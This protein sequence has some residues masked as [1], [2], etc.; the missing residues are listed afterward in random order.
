MTT[1]TEEKVN[2]KTFEKDLF[3]LMCQIACGLIQEYLLWRDLT[4]MAIRDKQRFR[5]IDS[6]RE[7]TIKTVFGEVRYVRR[8]Y[9]DNEIKRYIFLLDVALGIDDG[10]GLISENLAE[11]I[12][13]EAADKSY[14][15]AA[16]T[17][18]THTGQRISAQG[19]WNVL[20][21]YGNAIERQETRLAE[22]E[23]SG[24]VGHLGAIHTPVLFKEYDDLWIARQREKRRAKGTASKGAKMIGRALGKK[25]MCVGTAY[26]GFKV[27]HNGRCNTVNKTT[28]ASFGGSSKFRKIFGTLLNH[29]YDIDGVKWRIINGDGEEWIKTEAE[30]TDSIL[31][32]DPFH[33]CK[34]IIKT[35]SD[36][37][38]RERIFNAIKEK[39]VDG[40]LANIFELYMVTCEN[41]DE[42]AQ[43]KLNDLYK[44]FYNNKDNLLTWQERGLE[45]PTPPCGISYR[46]MGTQESNNTLYALRMKHHRGAWSES[47]ANNMARILSYR[48]TI[49]LETI[50]GTLPEP[51][52]IVE[53]YAEPLSAAQAPKCDGKGYGADWLHAPMPFE[54]AFTTNGREAIKGM[55]RQRPLAGLRQS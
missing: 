48:S 54:N 26:T 45:L 8:Y 1:I 33:R 50:L 15:K 21:Q 53:I 42:K 47:G 34:A 9:Y 36:N 20:Q 18:S 32:L 51:E 27:D 11:Q 16:D 3:K 22:L 30:E 5:L 12:V 28:Y 29:R 37:P 14:R 43:K 31:Q 23:D 10:Y 40:A 25:P 4:V 55:L 6:H 38:E 17:I 44:Y 39:D 52:P 2:F 41:Q 19:A 13:N 46:G 7:T 24:S 49:G 35:I